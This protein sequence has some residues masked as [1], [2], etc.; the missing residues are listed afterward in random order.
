MDHF[1]SREDEI[2]G[3][4]KIV[5]SCQTDRRITIRAKTAS[6]ERGADRRRAEETASGS[7]A[8]GMTGRN[9]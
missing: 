9:A 2:N 8:Q 3:N 7:G 6:A 1:L 4:L 5:S